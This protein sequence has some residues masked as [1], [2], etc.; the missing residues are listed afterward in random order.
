MREG[1]YIYRMGPVKFLTG[2]PFVFSVSGEYPSQNRGIATRR[3][4]MESKKNQSGTVKFSARTKG[5][6]EDLL[7]DLAECGVVVG[8]LDDYP[9]DTRMCSGL[10]DGCCD[11]TCPFSDDM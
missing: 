2:A 1:V 5:T 9:C 8:T 7:A 4:T 10:C 11:Y 6:L 3:A